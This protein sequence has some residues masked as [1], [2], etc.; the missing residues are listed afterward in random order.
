VRH[1]REPGSDGGEADEDRAATAE[2]LPDATPSPRRVESAAR[3]ATIFGIARSTAP[4]MRPTAATTAVIATTPPCTGCGSAPNAF[5]TPVTDCTIP[6]SAPSADSP[7]LIRSVWN[8]A[9]SF[10]TSPWREFI[11]P[12]A[13]ALAKPVSSTLL[14][15]PW[16]PDAPSL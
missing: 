6:R 16:I 9:A 7:A 2:D 13:C 5:T 15:Q 11:F 1:V 10:C 14:I 3:N 12:A 8:A 4:P